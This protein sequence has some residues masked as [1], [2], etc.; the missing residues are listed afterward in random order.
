MTWWHITR[1]DCQEQIELIEFC[2]D[3]WVV[4]DARGQEAAAVRELKL[5]RYLTLESEHAGHV[6]GGMIAGKCMWVPTVWRWVYGLV[7]LCGEE[8]EEAL[9]SFVIFKSRVLS[10]LSWGAL[11][12]GTL[13]QSI[14]MM[15]NCSTFPCVLR[16]IFEESRTR[17]VIPA[18]QFYNIHMYEQDS[19]L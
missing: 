19:R 4:E 18:H 1:S 11:G 8:Q 9:S 3:K 15:F 17:G 10:K 6:R 2:I 12:P 16:S 14:S 13:F 5:C 7:L